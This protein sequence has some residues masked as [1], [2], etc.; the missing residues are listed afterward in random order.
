MGEEEGGEGREA[1]TTVGGISSFE[2]TA[3]CQD[4]EQ[5]ERELEHQRDMEGGCDFS[6]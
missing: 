5:I 6:V 3:T 4:C 2:A 1:K